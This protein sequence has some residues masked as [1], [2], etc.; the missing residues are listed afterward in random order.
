M[1]DDIISTIYKFYPRNV[2]GFSEEYYST[3]E[4]HNLSSKIAGK[5][6]RWDNFF[7]DMKQKFGDEYVRD[8][9]D[10]E[11]C[12]RCVIYAFHEN[13]VFE[14]VIHISSLIDYYSF[15]VRKAVINNANPGMQE[16]GRLVNNTFPEV[17]SECNFILNSIKLHYNYQL[18]AED[19]GKMLVPDISTN[20]K[21]LGE[22]TIFDAV[23]ADTEL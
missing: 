11:P 7:A 22:T 20:N 8:R 2:S 4:Y 9:S 14:F 13:F 19:F 21:D 1:D 6:Q 15:Y 17:E 23:F 12:G 3:Q 18:M 16:V 10:E 5:D